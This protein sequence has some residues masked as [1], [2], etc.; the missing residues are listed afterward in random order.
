M[1]TGLQDT[2]DQAPQLIALFVVITALAVFAVALRLIARRL[3][4]LPLWWDDY[5]LIVASVSGA[6]GF[7]GFHHTNTFRYWPSSSLCY[8][9]K[10]C[11]PGGPGWRHNG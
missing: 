11:P 10:A 4:Q 1:A 7:Y 8:Y 2:T 5:L 9:M 6:L 3:A